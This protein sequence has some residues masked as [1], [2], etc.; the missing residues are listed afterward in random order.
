MLYHW[1]ESAVEW[2][3]KNNAT[4]IYEKEIHSKHLENLEALFL[5]VLEW[6]TCKM[7]L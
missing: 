6:K 7:P 2:N 3:E 5:I 1:R 4:I